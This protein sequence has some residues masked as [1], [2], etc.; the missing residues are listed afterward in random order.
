MANS[1]YDKAYESFAK[2]EINLIADTIKVAFVDATY[3]PDFSTH[4]FLTDLGAS[5]IWRSGALSGKTVTAG[6]FDATDLLVSG[7]S[8]PNAHAWVLYQDTGVDATSRLISY[9]DTATGLPM[10]LTGGD[11]RIV[12]DNGANRILVV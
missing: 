11:I 9:I 4:Q 10:P 3:A 7:P 8:G 6:V 1:G 5:L 12:F 2:G